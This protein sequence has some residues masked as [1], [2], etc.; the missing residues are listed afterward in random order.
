MSSVKVPI[1]AVPYIYPVPI[2]LVGAMVDG[3]PNFA[4]VGDC[5]IMGINPALVTVSLSEHHHTTK[6]ILEHRT[7]S[8][9]LPST[10]LLA[11]ADY[12]GM[13]SGRDVDKSALFEIFVGESADTPMIEECPVNLE[14]KI[15]TDFSIEHRHIFVA[16]VIQTHVTE[17]LIEDR[18]GR[19]MVADMQRLDPIL[20]ALDNKYYSAGPPVG[21]GYCEGKAL[22]T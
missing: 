18:D 2:V 1:G 9:N 19:R 21:T 12:C 20:Y 4:T 13:V 11:K 15:E 22:A 5:A 17:S 7:F 16:S 3:R 8:I 6:G 14:C 10:D